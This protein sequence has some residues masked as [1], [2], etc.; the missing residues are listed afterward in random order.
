MSHCC[1]TLRECCVQ[2]ICWCCPGGQ[3]QV[4]SSNE[5]LCGRCFNCLL[6]APLDTRGVLRY[7]GLWFYLIWPW[8]AYWLMSCNALP[9]IIPLT[10]WPD[11]WRYWGYVGVVLV[12]TSIFILFLQC[13]AMECHLQ[14]YSTL[15]ASN[16]LYTAMP[17]AV[18]LIILSGS[19]I[20]NAIWPS[21]VIGCDVL[22]CNS[23]FGWG[24]VVI[25]IIAL[26]ILICYTTIKNCYQL[27]AMCYNAQQR[28]PII[29]SPTSSP[30]PP[31]YETVVVVNEQHKPTTPPPSYYQINNNNNN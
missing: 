20:V 25:L 10:T 22:W 24:I 28:V 17:F 18:Y 4:V 23:L 11:I 29:S 16:T 26:A 14:C 7:G 15:I 5:Y 31:S 9:Q 1:Y 6:L 21:D 8:L 12:M 27:K 19:A 13:L 30:P 3:P 2:H